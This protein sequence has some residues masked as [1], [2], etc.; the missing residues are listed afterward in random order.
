MTGPLDHLPAHLKT[1]A[2]YRPKLTHPAIRLD[3]NESPHVVP[4][5]VRRS[6]AQAAAE[7]ATHRYPD[8]SARALK[9][10]LRSI[11]ERTPAATLR[12]G[13]PLDRPLV[14]G[15]GSDEI[16]AMLV[17]AFGGDAGAR[18]RV[19][20]PSPTFVMYEKTSRAHGLKPVHVPLG[21]G[22]DWDID[23]I[24]KALE[25]HRPA[26]VFYATPN[27]PTGR[28]IEDAALQSLIE[29]FPG[30]L[31]IIDE[32]YGA[33]ER[34]RRTRLRWAHAYDNV[35]VMGT[36]SK[37]GFAALRVGFLYAPAP[38][39]EALERVRQPY[40]LSSPIQAMAERL[41]RDHPDELNRQANAI[42]EERT[43]VFEELKSITEV[44]PSQG[45]FHL[46]RL[47]APQL[48]AL[49]NAGIGVRVFSD[50]K[51]EGWAR[52]SIG[53]AEE[54]DALLASLGAA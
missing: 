7:A 6:L 28:P 5:S 51:L 49:K 38:I 14:L 33:F 26:L 43:R 15:V 17:V 52:I 4:E 20:I 13:E 40:N 9:D 8:G 35:A 34:P 11:L 16:I 31:H 12:D 53:T 30:V 27:N 45:N 32:A 37:V 39:A 21:V 36:L 18:S 46:A 25:E 50:P 24:G 47:S 1:L 22:F 23:A 48:S 10:A 42:V 29:G 41:L 2:P 54:N 19:V 3:A 44:I